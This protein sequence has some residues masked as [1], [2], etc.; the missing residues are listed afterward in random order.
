MLSEA[1]RRIIVATPAIGG[2]DG[3]SEVT[4]Q[5]VRALTRVANGASIE[6]WCLAGDEPAAAAS[7]RE[8]E[9]RS[10]RGHRALFGAFSLRPHT[11]DPST[12]VVVQHLHLGP[13]MLPLVWRG[14]RMVSILHGIEAWKPLR[15]LEGL[16]LRRAWRIAAVSRQT[17]KRFRAANPDFEGLDIHVCHSAVPPAALRAAERRPGAFALIVARMA[18]DE[19]YKGHDA[20]LEIWPSIQKRVPGA[21][22]VV[23][24]DGDDRNRLEQKSIALG[25][26]NSVTFVGNVGDAQL[27]ALYDDASFFVMPSREEGLGL[28]YLEAMRAGKPCIAAPGAAEEI[29]DT[30]VHGLVVD[31]AE[32][33]ALADAIVRLFVDAPLRAEMGAACRLRVEERFTQERFSARVADLLGL[34]PAPVAC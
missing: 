4:R 27:S 29:I 8:V 19:R 6:I 24:G 22:L 18:A 20:L 2:H 17:A 33:E 26:A 10:A 15:R 23:A 28:V 34:Q 11:L 13:A 25:L 21:A 5:Y 32:R 9:V 31:P 3:I 14:A 7:G 16:A 1:P 30:G 12:V